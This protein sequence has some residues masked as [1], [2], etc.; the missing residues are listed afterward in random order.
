MVLDQLIIHTSLLTE[1]WYALLMLFS[2]FAVKFSI[3]SLRIPEL[4][5]E[6]PETA[7][8]GSLKVLDSMSF[9]VFLFRRFCSP[10]IK[11]T[12]TY[13]FWL[14]STVM[15]AVNALIDDGI[16]IGVLF[17]GKKVRDD[18]NTLSQTGLSCRE[19]LGNLGFTL[20]PGPEKQSVPLCSESP[21]ISVPT[22]STN[23]SERY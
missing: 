14:Q 13:H 19:N 8:V 18:N 7:T 23:L 2:L 12:D 16:R 1:T 3:K 4:F 9:P 15:E 6:V 22:D 11:I 5:I 21:I 10:G 20:E 17:Q